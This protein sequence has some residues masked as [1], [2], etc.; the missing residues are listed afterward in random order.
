ML[1]QP[2]KTLSARAKTSGFTLV[3][4]LI[5]VVIIVIFGLFLL[6]HS[7]QRNRTA[8][9]GC[10]TNQRQL[11]LGFILWSMDNNGKFPW[12]L[13]TATNGTMKSITNGE[14]ATQ[15]CA[16]SGYIPSYHAYLCPSETSRQPAASDDTLSDS[17]LSYFVNIDSSPTNPAI[18][19][20][21]ARHLQAGGEPVK[22]GL[23]L[24]TN[25]VDLG[26]THE[27]HNIRT[28]Q[29]LGILG[30]ADGHSQVVTGQNLTMTFNHQGLAGSHLLAPLF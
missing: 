18:V 27:L 17:N 14:A 11:G 24:F 28:F 26:W 21:G 29:T 8:V 25:G 16:L 13:S 10:L 9:L 20:T 12:Q 30:F 4:L 7:P 23:F 6:P 3:E 15:F 22:P 5:V 1:H 19:L 2:M